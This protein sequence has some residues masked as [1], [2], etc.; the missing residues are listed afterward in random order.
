M[1]VRQSDRLLRWLLHFLFDLRQQRR[2][3]DSERFADSHEHIDSGGLPV[4]FQHADI[5]TI[6]AGLKGQV[7]LRKTGP[8]ASLF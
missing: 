6:N 7:F 1:V 4:V 8:R 3:S 5:R 2:I